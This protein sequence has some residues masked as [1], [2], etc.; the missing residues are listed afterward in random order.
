[1]RVVKYT[2]FCYPKKYLISIQNFMI[3]TRFAPS[4]TGMLHVGN[5]RT[6]LYSYLFARHHGGK[7]M[8][9]VEDTDQGRFVEG[10]MENMIQSLKWGGI[11]IDEGVDMDESGH[12]I[13]KGE[14]GSYIQSERLPLYKK[15]ALELIEKGHAYYCF[16]TKER[17]DELRATQ[18]ATKQPTMYDGFCHTLS[19]EVVAKNMEAGMS[20]VVR[21]NTPKDGDTTFQ[22]L[23]RGEVTFQNKLIDD[24]VL[25][26]SDGFPTYHLAVVV[27]DH[28][29]EVTHV[30]RAEEWL[31]STPKHIILYQMFGWKVPEFAHLSWLINDQKQKLSKRHGDVS[32]EDFRAKG[33]LP[34]ALVNFISFL[35]WNP[36]DEREMFTVA[37]LEKEFSAEKIS[38]AG[39]VFNRDKLNWYNKEYIKK[40]DIV[41]LTERALPFLINAGIVAE[42]K[43]TE[44]LQKV[45]AL[46]KE[47]M[48]V[49]SELSESV[50]FVFADMLE[51]DPTILIW[52]KD[53][54]EGSKEKL[55]L[56]LAFLQTVDSEDWNLETLQEKLKTWI[57]EKGFGVGDVL[58]P[59]RVSLSGR[60]NSPGPFEIADVL[61]KEKTLTRIET[62]IQK[63]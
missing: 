37:E 40:M 48:T 7:F 13:Q 11:T 31:P 14:L 53:T 9:R 21:M 18:E 35:G 59:M 43:N 23:V 5:L 28:L 27:D 52:K 8:L 56:L 42:H 62:A 3:K 60:Q 54:R 16:C 1:M 55:S 57:T 12:L 17:L 61:G 20:Y 46:E 25:I 34:E 58:W 6:A 32:V 2:F 38:K 33:Y 45:V 36:G 30:L 22:D 24:Q 51:Y 29:M 47:R 63:L 19:A 44:W 15:Y 41:E 26:K 10:A 50:G 49:L 4:P 39:A